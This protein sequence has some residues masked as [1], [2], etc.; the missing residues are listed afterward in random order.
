[1]RE[2]GSVVGRDEGNRK[3]SLGGPYVGATG[4]AAEA[5]A[6]ASGGASGAA[7]QPNNADA[8]RLGPS[9]GGMSNVQAMNVRSSAMAS[10]GC[11][12]DRISTKRG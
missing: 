9:I 10:P 11:S 5:V 4:D 2:I 7:S 6:A 3:I 8:A 1:M 12:G